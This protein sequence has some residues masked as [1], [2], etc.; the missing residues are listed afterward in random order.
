MASRTTAVPVFLVYDYTL[1]PLDAFA[2]TGAVITP[3]D[4]I[5][6]L[7]LALVVRQMRENTHREHLKTGRPREM[8]GRARDIATTLVM[9]YGG[10]AVVAPWLGLQPSF[11]VSGALPCLFIMAQFLIDA[12]PSVPDMSMTEYPASL[13]DAFTRAMLVCNFVTNVP[14]LHHRGLCFSPP[15]Y[16]VSFCL[17]SEACHRNLTDTRCQ[18]AANGGPFLTSLLSLLSPAPMTLTTPPE[19][20]PSGWTSTDLWVAP[21]TTALFATLTHAQPFFT[22]L[23]VLLFNFFSPL[24][25]ANVSYIGVQGKGKLIAVDPDSARGVCVLLLAGCFVTRAVKN[26]GGPSSPGAPNT[27]DE[28]GGP[29]EKMQ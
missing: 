9:V 23:H 29:K 17:A 7:R 2:W 4:V 5:G 16:V 10:E 3:L 21:L 13:V 28:P 26:F 6:A 12:F 25:L 19:L 8:R 14:C 24:G 11:M 15:L 20:L 1:Q 18:I 27:D 22:S